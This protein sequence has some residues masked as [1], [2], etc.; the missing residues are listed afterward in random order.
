MTKVKYIT[1][2]QLMEMIENRENFKLVEV[3]QKQE[4]AIGHIPGAI[5]IPLHELE[6]SAPNMLSNNE[7]I[8]VY[9][10]SYSCQA[11]ARAARRLTEMG[12][13]KVL[14]FKAGKQW[15]RH[16]GLDLEK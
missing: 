16:A 4:F 5:N 8:V 13:Q 14:D 7:T 12:Y 15:W 9:C 11:S 10:A 3:L 2:E 6:V 1:L